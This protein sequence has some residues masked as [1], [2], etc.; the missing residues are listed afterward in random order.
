MILLLASDY[1]CAPETSV[2]NQFLKST[3]MLAFEIIHIHNNLYFASGTS[4]QAKQSQLCMCTPA[5]FVEVG[6]F[7]DKGDFLHIHISVIHDFCEM[8]HATA[9]THRDQPIIVCSESCDAGSICNACLLLGCYLILHLDLKP[10]SIL[11]EVEEI[12]RLDLIRSEGGEDVS[13]AVTDCWRAL[14]LARGLCWLGPSDSTFDVEMYAHYARE[15]NGDIHVL[16]PGKL[17]LFLAPVQLPAHQP[18]ADVCEAGRPPARLFSAPFLAEL[19]ADLDVSVVASL[20]QTTC[21]PEA[22]VER[23]LDVHDLGMDADR[24][25]LLGALDRLL[26]LAAAAPGA[27]AVFADA[28]AGAGVVPPALIGTLAAAFLMRDL[29]FDAAAATAWIRMVCPQLV[30]VG[31]S[32]VSSRGG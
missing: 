24:P 18:W 7:N 2:E 8:M 20:G 32:A 14:G 13:K 12:A 4:V 27:V 9:E 19:L 16:V 15:A 26:A 17:L 22:F 21:G 25:A 23:G 30:P 6:G 10:D 28:D 1:L 29:G 5:H 3:E 11:G 31:R